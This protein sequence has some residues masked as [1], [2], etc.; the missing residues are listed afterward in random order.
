MGNSIVSRIENINELGELTDIIV[1]FMILSF[2]KRKNYL[3][4]VDSK[5]R[6]ER[7]IDDI[8][9]ELSLLEYE[10]SIDEV[11]FHNLEEEQKK[12]LLREKLK[13]ITKELGEEIGD[14]LLLKKKIDELE[15]PIRIKTKLNEELERYKLC[16]SNSP[17]IGILRNYIDTLLMLPWSVST[18]EN[19]DLD[20]IR[21]SLDESHYGLNGSATQVERIFEPES[22]NETI[23]FEDKDS[24]DKLY[25]IL[26][27][28]KFIED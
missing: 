4:E 15:C 10:E 19:N 28:K 12:Y 21:K 5:K 23:I 8:Q 18:R 16:N 9:Y 11:T 24:V 14:D 17:E 1:S 2:E 3:Y 20:S 26:K 27:D 25:K 6:Y 22:N 13:I 7:L